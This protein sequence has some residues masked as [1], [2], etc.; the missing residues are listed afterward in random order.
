LCVNPQPGS[1]GLARYNARAYIARVAEE[2]S[3]CGTVLAAN[4]STSRC[5]ACGARVVASGDEAAP[6]GVRVH[7]RTAPDADY[8][9]AAPAGGVEIELR[10]Y[11]WLHLPFVALALAWDAL[12]AFLCVAWLPFDQ[13]GGVVLFLPAEALALAFALS[14]VSAVALLDKTRITLDAAELSVRRGP[15]PWLGAASVPRQSVRDV[16]AES[17]GA[18]YL[19]RWSLSAIDRDGHAVRLLRDASEREARYAA[20]ALRA[21]LSA[22]SRG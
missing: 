2:C 4:E 16:R 17:D 8:R 7:V 13:V 19:P 14:Y 3:A 5:P 11:C 10:L 21:V 1:S 15:L 9:K 18:S 22:A 6:P 20:R 12:T